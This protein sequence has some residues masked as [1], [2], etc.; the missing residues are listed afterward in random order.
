[1]KEEIRQNGKT[2]LES[3]DGLSIGMI[4]NN[5]TGVNLKGLEH[6]NYLDCVLL[7]M[8]LKKGKLEMFRDGVPVRSGTIR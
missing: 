2:V 7:P 1:M 8:G 3:E 4:F 5:L 6:R